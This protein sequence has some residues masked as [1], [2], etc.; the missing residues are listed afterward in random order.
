[1]VVLVAW[2]ILAQALKIGSA[3]ADQ[4]FG[5]AAVVTALA[6]CAIFIGALAVPSGDSILLLVSFVV[7]TLALAGVTVNYFT[8]PFIQ[9]NTGLRNLAFVDVGRSAGAMAG[10]LA[11]LGGSLSKL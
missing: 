5:D 8:N 6:L 1:V 11:D 3:P 10:S 7:A 9:A 4:L 2:Y